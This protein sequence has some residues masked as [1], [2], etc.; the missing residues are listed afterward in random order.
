MSYSRL[1]M[2]LYLVYLVGHRERLATGLLYFFR[3]N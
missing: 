2:K 1:L 3:E